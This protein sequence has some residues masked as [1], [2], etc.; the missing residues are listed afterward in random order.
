MSDAF[1]LDLVAL[2]P[3]EDE[4]QTL[5][6][7][8]EGRQQSL[9][10]RLGAHKVLKHTQHDAACYRDAPEVLRPYQ[11]QA[12][13]ALVVFDRV[14][15]GQEAHDVPAIEKAVRDRLATSG[16]NERGDVVVIDP[17]LENWV[18]TSSPHVA[19]ALGW[20]SYTPL[21]AWVEA[22]GLWPLN[23]PKPPDPK[24]AMHRAL[25]EAHARPSSA[26]FK[27]IARSTTL[28]GCL[29][30]AFGRLRM[31][32]S[33]WFPLTEDGTPPTAPPAPAGG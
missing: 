13:H 29:D 31:L 11:R 30:P 19:A 8:F 21:K 6:G 28:E 10:I 24:E 4:R 15:S 32:L 7:L 14:G 1:E 23:T 2:V 16:W 25:R 5:L 18:W 27:R 9:R 22:Q 3:G 33:T 20:K 12:R 17:E 26:I